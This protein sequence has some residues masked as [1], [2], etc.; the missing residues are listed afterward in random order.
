M[1]VLALG[2]GITHQMAHCDECN[3]SDGDIGTSRKEA[4]RHVEKTGHT[5]RI[6]TAIIRVYR[7]DTP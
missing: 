1:A 7:K 5:V 2:G 3:W 6:E 4:Y